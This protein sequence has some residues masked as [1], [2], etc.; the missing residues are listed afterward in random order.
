[1]HLPTCNILKFQAQGSHKFH[2]ILEEEKFHIII[3]ISFESSFNMFQQTFASIIFCTE[4]NHLTMTSNHKQ[5]RTPR[6]D[7]AIGLNSLDHPDCAENYSEARIVKRFT[8][9]QHQIQTVLCNQ[10]DIV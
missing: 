10:R 4:S 1:M 8:I 3:R 2:R 6:H 5:Q 9:C 7:P